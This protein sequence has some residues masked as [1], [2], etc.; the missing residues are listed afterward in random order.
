M[1][2]I[3]VKDKTNF[4]KA[5]KKTEGSDFMLYAAREWHRLIEDWVPKKT[6]RLNSDAELKPG[7]IIYRAPYA[8][9]IYRGYL[10][11][12][13]VYKVGGF[14]GDGKSFWSRRGV[15]KTPTAKKLDYSKN[16][17]PKASCRWDQ[18]AISEKQDLLLI[19]SMQKWIDRNI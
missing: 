11:V 1:L 12:D 19:R 6:G 8:S 2:K 5:I 7:K 3:R 15:K 4:S 17:N 13:P 9:Y 14:T 18:K 16:I 10:F